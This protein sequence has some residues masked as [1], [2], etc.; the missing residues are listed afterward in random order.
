MWASH[1][2]DAP[3]PFAW[4]KTVDDIITKVKRGRAALDRVTESATH[5]YRDVI[6]F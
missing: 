5:H 6:E 1:G 4:T 2:N 3:K